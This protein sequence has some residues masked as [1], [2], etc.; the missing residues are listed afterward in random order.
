MPRRSSA[1]AWTGFEHGRRASA[2]MTPERA[3]EICGVQ[4]E[5]IERA[6]RLYAKGGFS[7]NRRA[8]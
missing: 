5:D 4:A 2:Q 7:R 3:A 6:A 8:G 1:T